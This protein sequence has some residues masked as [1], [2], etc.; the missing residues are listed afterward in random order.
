MK[1]TFLIIGS[2]ENQ[3]L[4][5]RNR[6]LFTFINHWSLV[7][8]RESWIHLFCTYFFYSN[9]VDH[10]R[11][12]FIIS[13]MWYKPEKNP[14]ALCLR[15]LLLHLTDIID[16][17]LTQ[18]DFSQM[19]E[20]RQGIKDEHKRR[21]DKVKKLLICSASYLYLDLKHTLLNFYQSKLTILS[22]LAKK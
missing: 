7:F 10:H 21:E 6:I 4:N 19:P 15:R 22:N 13:V 1:Y 11:K 17:K 5:F 12:Y 18:G 14:V 16:L 2:S 8:E 20:D 9:Q 3:Q